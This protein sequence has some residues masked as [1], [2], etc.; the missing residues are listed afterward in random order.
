MSH[1][2]TISV[3]IPTYNRRTLLEKNLIAIQGQTLPPDRI[4][5]IIVNDG[6]TDDTGAMIEAFKPAF[7][8]KYVGQEHRAD[9]PYN[10]G[11]RLA[12]NDFILFLDDDVIPHPGTLEAH[13][14][15]HNRFPGPT[16]VIG[17]LHWPPD[18]KLT[19]FERYVGSSGILM[20]THLIK[21]PDDVHFKF[22]AGGNL[23]IPRELFIE[24]GG[25]DSDLDLYGHI[26]I[27]FGYRLKKRHGARLIHSPAAAADHWCCSPFPEFL[28]QRRLAGATAAIFHEK[29]PELSRYLK[30]DWVRRRG[31]FA[32]SVRNCLH[33]G[34]A[35]SRPLVPALESSVLFRPL[36]HFVYRLCIFYNFQRGIRDYL[37]E[38]KKTIPRD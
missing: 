27:E 12:E 5:V 35:L 38:K 19:P 37:S 7:R 15:A 18:K 14:A 26:D 28:K 22:S 17:S 20:G 13:V 4:E 16:A 1:G 6:G 29:H 2:S 33:A 24:S 10:V 9:T 25:F 21:D 31:P 8:L 23:S 32:W 30:V 3:V 36:L 11:A 34:S